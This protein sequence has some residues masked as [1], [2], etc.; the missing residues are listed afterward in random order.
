MYTGLPTVLG[1]EYHVP[2][3]GNSPAEIDTRRDAVKEIYASPSAAAVEGLLRRYHVGYVY[4]GRLERDTYP[5]AGLSKFAAAKDLFQLAYQ[6]PDVT[7]YRVVGG[8]SED[9]VLPRREALPEPAPDATPAAPESEPDTPPEIAATA[10]ADLSAWAHLKEPR[11]AAVDE[12]GRVWIAD[13]GHSRLRVFDA[14]GG[15]LGGWGGRGAGPHGFNEL[16]GVAAGKDTLAVADTWNGRILVFDLAGKPRASVSE[17]YGPRGVA[18]A[19]DGRI[20]AAD[21]GNGRVMRYEADLTGALVIGK[22]GS[23]KGELSGPIGIAVGPSGRVYVADT[24]NKRIQVIDRDGAFVAAWPIVAWGESSEPQIA[25]DSDETVYVTDPPGNALLEIGPDGR[26]LR[27][28]IA[29]AAGVPFSRPTGLALDRKTRMLYVINSGNSSVSTMS[30]PE[31]K[32][33]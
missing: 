11:G 24:G 2:Q 16:C 25:V 23:G 21:T 8:D 1:W 17:L 20:W 7:I 29:D 14:K 15:T 10:S 19:P 3:R 22:K 18:V 5:A 28:L 4:V 26:T 13:F 30:L 33:P 9:V 31:R 27:R 12:R 32:Q 6:N